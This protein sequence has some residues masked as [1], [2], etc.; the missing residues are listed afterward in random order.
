MIQLSFLDTE[1]TGQ[2]SW[3]TLLMSKCV[4]SFLWSLWRVFMDFSVSP[5][6]ILCCLCI[7]KLLVGYQL[8]DAY[9]CNT[10]ND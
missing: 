5:D 4:A 1:L 6:I 2:Y 10:F 9:S 3:R 7:H 8:A